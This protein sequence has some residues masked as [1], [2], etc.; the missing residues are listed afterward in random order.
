MILKYIVIVT[1]GI[2]ILARIHRKRIRELEYE[3][4]MLKKMLEQKIKID[5]EDFLKGINNN[6]NK[7]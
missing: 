7:F 5:F 2:L 4:E 6:E 1:I 3:I